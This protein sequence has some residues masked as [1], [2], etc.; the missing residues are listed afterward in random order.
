MLAYAQSFRAETR[1]RHERITEFIA[2]LARGCIHIVV[3]RSSRA[4]DEKKRRREKKN[5]KRIV[6]EESIRRSVDPEIIACIGSRRVIFARAIFSTLTKR[7][8]YSCWSKSFGF[9]SLSVLDFFFENIYCKRI[10][11]L[12]RLD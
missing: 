10:N 4:P 6:E 12:V 5:K 7:E 3:S 1:Y 2:A 9:S 11:K 8:F